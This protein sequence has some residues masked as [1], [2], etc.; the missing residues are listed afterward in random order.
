MEASA[1]R[2][3]LAGWL[4]GPAGPLRVRSS[5]ALMA[6]AVYS[7]F[8]LLQHAE[9]MLG[10]IDR[11]ESNSLTLFNLCGASGLP[12]AGRSELSLR[13][14]R[15]PSLTMPQMVFAIVSTASSYVDHRPG[16]RRA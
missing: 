15:E 3:R 9:V 5:M 8:A 2:D 6:L 16:A 11:A 1:R 13:L 7:V 4:L 12:C 14:S 10:L